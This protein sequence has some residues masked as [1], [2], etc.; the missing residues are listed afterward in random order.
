[1]SSV[2]E[3]RPH[4]WRSRGRLGHGHVAAPSSSRADRRH[5]IRGSAGDRLLAPL[6]RHWAWTA[7]GLLVAVVAATSRFVAIGVLPPSIKPK[8]FAHATASTQLVV[9]QGQVFTLHSD[10]QYEQNYSP[11]GLALADMVASPEVAQ[12][13]ARAAGI[14]ASKI[15]ILGPQWVDLQRT[16]QWATGPKRASQIIVEDAPYH[17]TVDAAGTVISVQTQAPTTEAAARLAS[18][19]PAGLNAFLAHLQT[20]TAVPEAGRYSVNQLGPVSSSPARTSQLANVGIFTFITV[21]VLWCGGM[22][23]FSGLMRDLRESAAR[24]K[25]GRGLDRSSDSRPFPVGID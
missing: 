21:F 18:A 5:G 1:M 13:V 17:I 19:V 2:A 9:A 3:V 15:G 7:L 25:V 23:A 11:R 12:Y 14:P 8:P 20:T 24:S 4:T 6:R 10:D 22:L 16:Q